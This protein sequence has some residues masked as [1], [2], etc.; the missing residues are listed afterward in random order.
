ML[1]SVSFDSK[2]KIQHMH[3]WSFAYREARRS[4]WLS[5]VSDRQR[6]ETRKQKL[7]EE[8]AKI[9]FFSKRK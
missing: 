8:L 9:R 5:V 4:N 3:T 6:F 1:K 2:V 7:E